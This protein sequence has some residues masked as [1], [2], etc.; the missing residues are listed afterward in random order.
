MDTSAELYDPSTGH[1]TATEDMNSA[2]RILFRTLL[3][4]FLLLQRD[5][6][7]DGVANFVRQAFFP[8]ADRHL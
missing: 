7:F 2:P 3:Q 1:F 8:A 5:H 4:E 6:P